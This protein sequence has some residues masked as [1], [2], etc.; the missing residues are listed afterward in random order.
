[1]RPSRVVTALKASQTKKPRLNPARFLETLYRAYR[2]LT[3]KDGAGA[4][5]ALTTIYDAFTLGPV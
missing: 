2:L 4:T 5:V 1:V 3:G